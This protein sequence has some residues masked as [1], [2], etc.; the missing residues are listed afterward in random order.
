MAMTE[1][2]KHLPRSWLSGCLIWKSIL[3]SILIIWFQ[4][5]LR[6]V[7][8]EYH[9]IEWSSSLFKRWHK[10]TLLELSLVSIDFKKCLRHLYGNSHYFSRSITWSLSGLAMVVSKLMNEVASAI[11][12]RNLQSCKFLLTKMMSSQQANDIFAWTEAFKIT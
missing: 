3:V 5:S 6:Y 2:F 8:L 1:S 4:A 9:N 10:N 11:F 7:F 12:N